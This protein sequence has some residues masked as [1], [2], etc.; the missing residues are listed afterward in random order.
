MIFVVDLSFNF[1]YV[2]AMLVTNFCPHCT[3]WSS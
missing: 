2:A 3:V 1:F